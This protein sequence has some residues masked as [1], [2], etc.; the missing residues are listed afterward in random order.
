MEITC[1]YKVK[2]QDQC[3]GFWLRFLNFDYY[4]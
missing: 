4:I 1:V 3:L 2:V